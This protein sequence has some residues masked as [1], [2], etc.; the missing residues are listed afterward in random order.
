MVVEPVAGFVKNTIQGD[1]EVLLV[2]ACG[3]PGVVRAQTGTE[4]VGAGVESTGSRIKADLRK[5]GLEKFLLIRARII[6]RKVLAGR[7]G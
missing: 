6:G 1:H 3:H 5:E 4:G 2:V 7:R